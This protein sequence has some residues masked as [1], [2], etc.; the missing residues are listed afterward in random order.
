M[1]A[2][3]K[4]YFETIIEAQ[5]ARITELETMVFGRKGNQDL[6]IRPTHI[7]LSATL[8]ATSGLFRVAEALLSTLEA[9]RQDNE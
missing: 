5:N 7:K 1:L 8:L 3:Q 2:E 6:V 4:T 9:Q